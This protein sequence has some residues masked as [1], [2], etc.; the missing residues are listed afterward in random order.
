METFCP[1]RG[2]PEKCFQR[3]ARGCAPPVDV[4]RDGGDASS[5]NDPVVTPLRRI[6]N[7]L[8]DIAWAWQ[9]P[10]GESVADFFNGVDNPLGRAVARRLSISGAR[11]VA[12]R[13]APDWSNLAA[14]EDGT[15]VS[16]V[17]RARVAATSLL[18]VAD[19]PVIGLVLGFPMRAFKGFLPRQR[20]VSLFGPLQE[21]VKVWGTEAE[22]LEVAH[23]FD[24]VGPSGQRVPILVEGARLMAKP[25]FP[26]RQVLEESEIFDVIDLP[27]DANRTDVRGGFLWDQALVEVI[28]PK[29]NRT[30]TGAAAMSIGDTDEPPTLIIPRGLPPP[31]VSDG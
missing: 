20:R 5:V 1:P 19:R 21:P 30:G 28:G 26:L 18:R 4:L 17:G 11:A 15:I 13:I 24:L 7:P 10:I 2:S 16:V 12:T 9:S 8:F 29:N 25:S 23:D 27:A 3:T 6:S 31:R 22:Q 14:I